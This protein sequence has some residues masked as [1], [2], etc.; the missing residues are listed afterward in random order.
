M[1]L[2]IPGRIKSI[3]LQ[4]NGNIKMAKVS[5]GGII[6]EAKRTFQYLKEILEIVELEDDYLSKKEES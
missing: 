3:A 2:A 4:D 1:C 5:F 6:K